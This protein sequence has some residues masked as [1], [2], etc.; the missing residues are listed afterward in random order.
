MKN[1]WV[2]ELY[3]YTEFYYW[4]PGHLNK[5]TKE[6]KKGIESFKEVQRNIRRREVPLN[7][8]MNIAMRLMPRSIIC[9]IFQRVIKREADFGK[10]LGFINIYEKIG[11]FKDYT[12]P[13]MVFESETSRVFV[14]LK[15]DANLTLDQVY[16][17]IFLHGL[18]QQRTNVM[19]KPYI[20]F[21]IKNDL[22]YQWVSKERDNLFRDGCDIKDV[23]EYIKNKELPLTLGKAS[24]LEYLHKDVN[25]IL[26]DLELGWSRW[27]ELGE[28]L[29]SEINGLSLSSM[30]DGEE[31]IYKLINDILV[32][33]ENRQLW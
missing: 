32:D 27:S 3:K 16:K 20:L 33:L 26:G 17:Y 8:I 14:E 22:Q 21:I 11:A 1:T 15:I 19:K 18:W 4:E 13:D 7:A 9:K 10:E 2:E 31:T 28:I 24:S 30:S 29:H 6:D 12:Q 25:T 23:I 5:V